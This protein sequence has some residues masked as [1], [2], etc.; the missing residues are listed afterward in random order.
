MLLSDCIPSDPGLQPERTA[1]AWT[2]TASGLLLNAVLH[3]RVSFVLESKSLLTFSVTL[4][5]ASAAAFLFGRHRHRQL[6]TGLRS[7]M[8]V[9]HQAT[10]VMSIAA[11]VSSAAAILSV[12]LNHFH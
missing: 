8:E 12:A 6:L 3:L 5:V 9:S 10:F 7:G 4:L 1:L 11:L 2:R